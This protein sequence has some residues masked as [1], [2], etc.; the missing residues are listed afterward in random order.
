VTVDEVI[1]LARQLGAPLQGPRERPIKRWPGAPRCIASARELAESV[2]YDHDLLNGAWQTALLT[3]DPTL[4][5]LGGALMVAPVGGR[6]D[7]AAVSAES[8]AGDDHQTRSHRTH[9]DADELRQEVRA[10]VLGYTADE[11]ESA[12]R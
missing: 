11:P 4:W 2:G 5:L 7:D 10:K 3:Q 6:G 12:A 9:R 1:A 8:F